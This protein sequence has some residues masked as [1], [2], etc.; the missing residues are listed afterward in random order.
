MKFKLE[1]V[2]RFFAWAVRIVISSENLISA[3]GGETEL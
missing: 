2:E 3:I 1:K